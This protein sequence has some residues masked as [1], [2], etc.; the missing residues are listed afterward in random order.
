MWPLYHLRKQSTICTISLVY[1]QS[2]GLDEAGASD[3]DDI[4]SG[5]DQPH[6]SGVGELQSSQRPRALRRTDRRRSSSNNN[7]ESLSS[8]TQA[9][10]AAASSGGRVFFPM[11]VKAGAIQRIAEG[12]PQTQVAKDLECPVST[13]ASWWVR[14]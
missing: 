3:S 13:V 5:G 2:L 6:Q 7:V 9:E 10:V 8:L 1:F 14:R 4:L 12:V 11:E